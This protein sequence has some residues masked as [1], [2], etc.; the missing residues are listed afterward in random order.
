MQFL[1][2]VQVPIYR[3]CQI[4]RCGVQCNVC[5][6]RKKTFL[7]PEVFYC[8]VSSDKVLC[9]K[10]DSDY[11]ELDLNVKLLQVATGQREQPDR[12]TVQILKS[13]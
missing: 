9:R 1:G 5:F 6:W 12:Q 2:E 10:S 13:Y 4:A 8:F 7:M 11:A 3:A